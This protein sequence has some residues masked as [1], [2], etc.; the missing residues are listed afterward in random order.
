MQ[1]Q[2]INPPVV[3]TPE[4]ST[5]MS[6]GTGT[7]DIRFSWKNEPE[8]AS[9]NLRI[10]DNAAM[11][12]P[13]ANVRV[14]A[15]YYVHNVATGP[16]QARSYYWTVNQ[17]GIDGAVSEPSRVRRFTLITGSAIMPLTPPDGHM[18]LDDDLPRLR[19]GWQRVGE[20]EG[21]TRF[22]LSSSPNFSTLITNA[23]VRGA[24]YRS[25]TLAPGSYYWRIQLSDPASPTVFSATRTLLVSKSVVP[26][27]ILEYPAPRQH[28]SAV[29]A[30]QRLLSLR[31]SVQ[32]QEVQ[33]ARLVLSTNPDPFSGTP[34]MDVR[35]P[36]QPLPLISLK[37]GIYYWSIRA[38]NSDG[39]DISAER[40]SSFIVDAP[41]PFSAPTNRRPETNYRHW[42]R[43]AETNRGIE[44]SWNAVPGANRYIL[45]IYGMDYER[46]QRLFQTEP[47][48]ATNFTF[49]DFSL[50]KGS[51]FMWSVEAVLTNTNGADFVQ[52]GYPGENTFVVDY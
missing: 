41:V 10:A 16:L 20:S 23:V 3:M 40:P 50:L 24:D 49:S 2:E 42:A 29:T 52:R 48:A 11:E 39:K 27:I 38:V 13:L 25:A 8:A 33:D 6:L 21:E 30:A 19:F 4:D 26:H 9:Y 7:G 18:V 32:N 15:N 14:S 44:F 43:G 12:R 17:T 36:N 28:I 37:P 34:L 31:W 22:Q 5:L 1:T 51:Y 35:A 45:T 46:R 47:I